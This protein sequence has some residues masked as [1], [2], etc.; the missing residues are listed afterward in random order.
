MTPDL[1]IMVTCTGVT[2]VLLL[3]DNEAAFTAGLDD[4]VPCPGL[5][6]AALVNADEVILAL[7]TDLPT[8]ELLVVFAVDKAMLTPLCVV[9]VP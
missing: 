5:L 6:T 9:A 1:E 8:A 7:C 4:T 2:T 3:N